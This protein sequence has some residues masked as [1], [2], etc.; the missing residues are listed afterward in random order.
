MDE[1]VHR[2][3]MQ[4]L[5]R[6]LNTVITVVL[7]LGALLIFGGV[8]LRVLSLSCS[9]GLLQAATHLFLLPARCGMISETA[10]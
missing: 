6:T 8:T 10:W 1:L 7:V 4:T 9:L 5:T 2:S 3:I